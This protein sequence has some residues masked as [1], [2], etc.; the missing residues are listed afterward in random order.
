MGSVW[1]GLTYTREM[2]FLFVLLVGLAIA[3]CSV[4]R[5]SGSEMASMVTSISSCK[6]GKP[7]PVGACD[8]R[9]TGLTLKSV[10]FSEVPRTALLPDDQSISASVESASD[11]EATGYLG[12]RFAPAISEYSSYAGI[13]GAYVGKLDLDGS[14]TDEG[15][16]NSQYFTQLE[17]KVDG[18]MSSSIYARL[19]GG[20]LVSLGVVLPIATLQSAG[21]VL[22]PVF[23][24]QHQALCVLSAKLSSGA[25]P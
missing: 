1:R 2:R 13:Y 19:E 5:T 11:A 25:C 6:I 15:E 10:V 17:D 8:L 12:F 22:S 20:Y 14:A 4:S 23:S 16:G 7:I 18:S 21:G 24:G 9:L 3:G